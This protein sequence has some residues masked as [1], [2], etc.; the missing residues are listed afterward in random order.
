MSLAFC[1]VRLVPDHPKKKFV[2]EIRTTDQSQMFFSVSK[3]VQVPCVCVCVWLIFSCEFIGGYV[4][5]YIYI[6]ICTEEIKQGADLDNK[7]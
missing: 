1:D 5:E 4:Y 2:F 7:L 3:C 6:Y